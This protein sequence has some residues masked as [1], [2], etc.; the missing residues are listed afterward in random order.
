M[1]E[2]MQVLE[3]AKIQAEKKSESAIEQANILIH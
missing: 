1:K 3:V 2:Q